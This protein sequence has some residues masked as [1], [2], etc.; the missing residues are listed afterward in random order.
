MAERPHVAATSAELEQRQLDTVD[1]VVQGI[2]LRA[3]A[4][5]HGC[6]LGQ[7]HADYGAGMKKLADRSMD[8]IVALR[9]EITLRQKSL[10]AANMPAARAGD[11]SAALIVQRA[12]ELLTS[13]WGLRSLKVTMAEVPRDP[14]IAEA[15]EAYLTGIA[16][17]VRR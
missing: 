11:K 7:V 6:S 13:V 9:D 14:M 15:L 4:K 1:L 2:P 3:I 10:I 12:D 8:A 5:K 16:E 17:K